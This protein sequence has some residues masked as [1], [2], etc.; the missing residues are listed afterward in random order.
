[1]MAP[2][3]I[4]VSCERLFVVEI[5][6]ESVVAKIWLEEDACETKLID[7]VADLFV[8]V[9]CQPSVEKILFC[10]GWHGR[11]LAHDGDWQFGAEIV[12][13]PFQNLKGVVNKARQDK[14]ADHD[15]A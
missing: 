5:R 12:I 7:F 14:M 6:H 10:T 8:F 13:K 3:V 15:A 9:L 2:L 11:E 1:M 4:A